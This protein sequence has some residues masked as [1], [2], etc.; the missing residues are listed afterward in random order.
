MC[1]IAG[2]LSPGG[3]GRGL[4]AAQAMAALIAH[5]GPDADGFL[6]DGPVSLANRPLAVAS[7]VKAFLALPEFQPQLDA[8]AAVEYFTFQNVFSD[9]T[10]FAGVR[11]LPPGSTLRVDGAGTV[12][13]ERYWA[14]Q[15]APEEDRGEAHY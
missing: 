2:T 9:R 6:I 14:F 12:K 11:M 15:F 7:E 13:T 10:L 1:G 4:E 5:R 8:A 3:E